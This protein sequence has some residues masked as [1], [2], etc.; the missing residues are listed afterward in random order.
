MAIGG[1]SGSDPV[2]TLSEFEDDVAQHKVAYYITVDN[3]GHGPSLGN[4]GHAD[5][6]NWVAATFSSRTVGDTTVYDLST[7]K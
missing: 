3:R 6:A 5:I 7:P 4:R 1:F 2:P